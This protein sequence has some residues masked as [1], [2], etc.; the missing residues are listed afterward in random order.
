MLTSFHG[1]IPGAIPGGDSQFCDENHTYTL[2]LHL[3]SNRKIHCG[4]GGKNG[5]GDTSQGY[6]LV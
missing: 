2:L 6:W 4:H 3:A 5:L 1:D